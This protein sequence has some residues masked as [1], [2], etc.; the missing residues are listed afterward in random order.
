MRYGIEVVPFGG[1]SDPRR[2]VRLAQAAEAAGWEGLWIWDHVLFPWGAG[3]PWITLAAVAASTRRLKLALGVSPL[4]RYRPHLLARMLASLDQLSAGRV[5]YGTGLGIAP[6]F[7]PFGEPG[8]DKTRAGMLD[9]GL[10]LLAGLLSGEEVT[11]HGKH[12]HAEK[13]RLAP[14]PLQKPRIPVWIGGGSPAAFRRA[15]RWD[16]WIMGTVD[17]QS[18]IT[19]PPEK[20][21][22]AVSTILAQRPAGAPIEVAVDGV[23]RPG[24]TALPLEYAHAGATWWFEAIHLS[25]GSEE[26]LLDRIAAGPPGS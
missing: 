4:P 16:G 8:D 2:I 21:A 10:E 3:D 25:R 17:E 18:H 23:T 14:A 13:V 11:H 22:R 1:F 6:D 26:E 5:I 12:Y 15:A 7:T 19:Y 9:E 24:E 20:V